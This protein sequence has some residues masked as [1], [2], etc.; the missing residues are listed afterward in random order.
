MKF[1]DLF[2]KATHLANPQAAS[3]LCPVFVMIS[4]ASRPKEVAFIF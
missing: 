3:Y 1:A 2:G 4:Y